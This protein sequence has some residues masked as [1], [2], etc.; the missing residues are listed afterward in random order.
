MWGGIWDHGRMKQNIKRCINQCVECDN[1]L[2]EQHTEIAHMDAEIPCNFFNN[3]KEWP[4]L[5]Q[6]RIWSFVRVVFENVDVQT[7]KYLGRW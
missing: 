6:W 7:W 3:Y 1:I 2:L 4:K 5:K